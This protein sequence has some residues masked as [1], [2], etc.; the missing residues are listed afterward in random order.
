MIVDNSFNVP[1]RH[2]KSL[3]AAFAASSLDFSW[4]TG[5]LKPVGVTPDFCRRLENSR[6]FYACLAFESASDGML[7]RMGRGYTARQVRSALD[8]LSRSAIPFSGSVLLGAPGETPETI[9]ETLAVLRD[10]EFPNGLWFTLGVYLWTGY[11][12]IVAGLLESG[13]LD[14]RDLFHGAVYL[15][16]GLPHSYL[17]ELIADLRAH[18]GYSVQVNKPSEEWVLST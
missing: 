9:A 11:Q 4:G 3:C 1:R 15:S 5:D 10:Y 13:E 14:Q 18:P 16:P 7:Q 2:S 17:S 6:C 12:D 8:A